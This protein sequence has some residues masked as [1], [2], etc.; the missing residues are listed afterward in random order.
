M[1]G[2]PLHLTPK[3]CQSPH[4]SH[5]VNLPGLER[6]WMQKRIAFLEVPTLQEIHLLHPCLAANCWV[7]N[8]NVDFG[9]GA[10]RILDATTGQHLHQLDC[11]DHTGQL[12]STEHHALASM[13]IV[14]PARCCG[15]PC[16]P[17]VSAKGPAVG[18]VVVEVPR[19]M[20]SFPS[21][22]SLA[23]GSSHHHRHHSREMKADAPPFRR[24][25]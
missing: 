4:K 12:R 3:P 6:T 11:L 2:I 16:P 24:I 19:M 9:A 1:T 15:A 20:T 23:C 14:N 22:L 8:W 21:A 13:E 18:C 17:L 5:T 10:A 25:E 7:G